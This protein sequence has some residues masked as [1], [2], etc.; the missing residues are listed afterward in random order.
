MS[1]IYTFLNFLGSILFSMALVY[2]DITSVLVLSNVSWVFTFVLAYLFLGERVYLA[3][4]LGSAVSFLGVYCLLSSEASS[5]V[6]DAGEFGQRA[7]LGKCFTILSAGC[8][9]LYATF[10]N[11]KMRS[12]PF[13]NDSKFDIS[14]FFGLNGLIS[15]VVVL[16]L[17][18][19]LHMTGVQPFEFPTQS[20]WFYLTLRAVVGNVVN[21]FFFGKT[22]EN[23]GSFLTTIGL[24]L[25]IPLGKM[26]DT[27]YGET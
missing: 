26:V 4:V 23:L 6:S 1:A 2:A 20:V 7:L 9:S 18:F 3:K 25:N 19:I 22:L 27:W 15:F 24:S 5:K 11:A 10:L 17:V 16:P 8:Y 21:D 13:K 14:L 12:S